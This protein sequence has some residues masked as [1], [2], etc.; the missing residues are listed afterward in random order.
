MSSKN[1]EKIRLKK[2]TKATVTT[3][4]DNYIDTLLPSNERVE[5]APLA[6]GKV[7]RPPLL[8]EHGF[9]I[10][11]EVIGDDTPIESLWTLE[12]PA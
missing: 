2:A 3:I 8:A 5:R 6:K 12:S 11:V 7:R 1:Q 4:I 10:L 9:S